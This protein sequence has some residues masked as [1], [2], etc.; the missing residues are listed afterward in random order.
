MTRAGRRFPRPWRVIE[1]AESFWV[2]DASGW[3]YF[4]D[5][6]ETARHTGVLERD[7]ALRMAANFV[8]L[9]ELIGKADRD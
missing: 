2:Q 9:P 1:R 4:R 3:F 7:E 6:P 5:H 8:L